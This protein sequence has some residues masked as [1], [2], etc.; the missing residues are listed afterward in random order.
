MIEAIVLIDQTEILQKL[1]ESKT[2]RKREHTE[3][4]L[5]H[6]I[7]PYFLNGSN[8]VSSIAPTLIRHVLDNSIHVYN[9]T[10]CNVVDDICNNGGSAARTER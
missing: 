2:A 9:I 7:G 6:S 8:S 10:Q 4:F 5:V 3:K 1:P